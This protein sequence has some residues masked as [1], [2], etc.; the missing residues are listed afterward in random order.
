MITFPPLGTLSRQYA[1]RC[2]HDGSASAG[3]CLCAHSPAV[4]IPEALGALRARIGQNILFAFNAQAA[5]GT[6]R[7]SYRCES[8]FHH[9]W[10]GH[11]QRTTA[12]R[13]LLQSMRPLLLLGLV[14]SIMGGSSSSA[15]G[16]EDKTNACGCYQNTAGQCICT[17][18]G[19]CDCPGECEPKGCD[20]KRQKELDK[21]IQEETRKAEAAEK[22]RQEE[23]AQKQRKADEQAAEDGSSEAT[24]DAAE[25][26]KAE[27]SAAEGKTKEKG[28]G[29]KKGK[30]EKSHSR[31]D[32]DDDVRRRIDW[33]YSSLGAPS[34]S[35]HHTLAWT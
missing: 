23:A 19:K 10:N 6:N 35:P 3:T 33:A 5:D 21:A 17:R 20:E 29:K 28:K 34:S 25:P 24:N 26:Q 15:R 30:D 32:E 4:K 14:A 12:M 22:K 2:S 13:K 9:S 31:A 27:E 1:W 11:L 7:R 16:E 18:R 8:V